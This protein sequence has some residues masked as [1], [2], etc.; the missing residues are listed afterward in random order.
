[1]T[2]EVYLSVHS[3]QQ[4][5]VPVRHLHFHEQ[6]A[7]AGIERTGGSRYL[8]GKF[9]SGIFVHGKLGGHPDADTGR[10]RLRDADQNPYGADLRHAEHFV[11]VGGSDACHAHGRSA[12]T[13]PG[14]GD[15][16]AVID[17]AGGHNAGEWRLYGLERLQR[18]HAVEVRLCLFDVFLGGVNA[19]FLSGDE[20]VGRRVIGL[21]RVGVLACDSAFCDEIVVA[22]RGDFGEI[23]L[24]LR[25]HERGARLAEL[26]LRLGEGG[27]CLRHLIVELRRVDFGH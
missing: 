7:G 24:R 27:A 19:R 11:T 13:R 1:M 2:V 8:A 22:L 14:S 26:L 15:Q 21:L 9:A 18:N 3:G 6:R 4:L 12:L 17:I 10:V 20:R 16:R 5:A 23:A 25:L